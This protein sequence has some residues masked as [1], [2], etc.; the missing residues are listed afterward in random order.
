MSLRMTAWYAGTSFLLILLATSFLYWSFGQRLSGQEDRSLLAFAQIIRPM[1]G[2]VDAAT[3]QAI[4]TA[5]SAAKESSSLRLRVIG[6]NGRISLQSPGMELPLPDTSRGKTSAREFRTIVS[7]GETFRMLTET[8]PSGQELQIA[9]GSAASQALLLRY[10]E[11]L[12]LILAISIILCAVLGYVIARSGMR[13][14]EGIAA[15]AERIR[16]STLHERLDLAGLPAE[17]ATLANTFNLMLDRLEHSFLQLSQFSADLAHELRTPIG[18][19]RGE[20]E[21]ALS[22][23]RSEESYREVLGSA[24]EECTRITR[25]IQSLLFLARAEMAGQPPALETLDLAH[26]IATVLEFYQPMAADADLSLVDRALPGIVIRF[27]RI[28]LQQALG[29]LIAN[30]ITHT[31]PGGQIVVQ[32][33]RTEEEVMIRVQDTGH[34]IAPEHLPHVFG[35]FYRADPARSHVGGNLGLGL[36]VVRAIMDLHSGSVTIDSTPH[37]GTT[38]SLHLP[39]SQP[40]AAL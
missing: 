18:N 28:L 40:I 22:R 11:T 21:V 31:E 19:L 15:T 27:D 1:V 34:G 16:S 14:I 25:I 23:P 35:R 4:A 39:C 30:A 32:A 2:H 3:A 37:Q 8:L 20:L 12:T 26:E 13:P 17:L 6:A 5:L 38:V 24:L 10:R 33:T 9:V 7:H 29:N 36:A